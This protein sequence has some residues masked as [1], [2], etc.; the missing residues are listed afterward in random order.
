MIDLKKLQ[1]RPYIIGANSMLINFM[2]YWMGA[3]SQLKTQ[4]STPP[5]ATHRHTHTHT[6]TQTYTSQI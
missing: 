5:H 3:A 6:D 1:Y 2:E 4:P